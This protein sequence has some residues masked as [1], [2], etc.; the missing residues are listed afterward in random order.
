MAAEDRNDIGHN[1]KKSN[2]SC[3]QNF[4]VTASALTL[5]FV[6]YWLLN[7]SAFP[8]FDDVFIWTRELSA[9]VG[10]LTL[11][12]LA[13][14]SY[15]QPQRIVKGL[16]T[17]GV[18]VAMV[19]GALSIAG[20]LVFHSSTMAVV[21]ASLVTVGSGLAN[22]AVGMGCIG[23]NARTLGIAIAWAYVASFVLRSLFIL[24]PAS[25]NLALFL[26]VPIASVLCVR[27]AF[28]GTFDIFRISGAPASFVVTTPGSFIPFG[29]QIFISL[30]VFRFVYGYTLTFGEVGRVPVV[31]FLTLAP[32]VVLLAWALLKRGSLSPD[33]LFRAS[34]LLS[35]AGFLTVSIAGGR[36]TLANV[37]LAS[38]TGFFEILMYYVLI[39][40][41]SKNPSAVLPSLAWGNAMASWGT[42]LGAVSGRVTNSA[43]VSDAHVLV[44]ISAVIVFLLVAYVVLILQRFSFSETIAQVV[45]VEVPVVKS[46]VEEVDV[47]AARAER[48]ADEYKL[49]DREREVFDLLAHGRNAR[50]IQ[51]ALTVSYNTVKTHVSHIYTK[52]GVH[53]QQELI[54]LVDRE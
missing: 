20:G 47:I 37:L 8:L 27:R 46:R 51:D 10:G 22:I 3:M 30:V 31:S 35:V 42:I 38:G 49:T 5:T 50:F 21:G 53:T 16:F 9:C 13:C 11:A 17:V 36:D 23:L 44:T 41:G 4:A 15:W 18:V 54:D 43:A 26:C 32:L 25:V 29:H 45:K 39:S 2:S 52:L 28:S 34:V 6:Q 12:V 7:Y 40:L 24:L 19:L 1:D 33:G 14:V 48:L